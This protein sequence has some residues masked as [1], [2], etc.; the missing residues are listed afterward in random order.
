MSGCGTTRKIP[1][2]Q[3]LL[4]QY[5]ITGLKGKLL[6]DSRPYIRQ[7]PNRKFLGIGF[8]KIYLGIYNTF[9]KPARWK[10]NIRNK[11]GERP[12]IYDS[13]L[14]DLSASQVQQYLF[15]K[16]YFHA[17]VKA[18]DTIHHKK[19]YVTYTADKGEPYTIRNI[20]YS[21]RD[22]MIRTLYFAG[23]NRSK[24][25]LGAIYDQ[26][27]MQQERERITSNL[28]NQGYY[29]FNREYIHFDIDSALGTNQ[30]DIYLVIENR[31]GNIAHQFYRVQ[32][33]MVNVKPTIYPPPIRQRGGSEAHINGVQISDS[34]NK[35]SPKVLRR[36]VYIDSNNLYRQ[37][38]VELTYNRFGD[39]GVFK[40]T[41]IEFRPNPLD[42]T[43]LDCL[44]ELT[45]AERQGTQT[46]L[47]GYAASANVGASVNFIYQNRNIFKGAEILEFRVRGGLE[48][49]AFIDRQKQ[50]GIPVFNSREATTSA[51][52][53]FPKFLFL[54]ENT[55]KG[56]FASPRTRLGFT[57]SFE[58][59]P[60]YLRRTLNSAFT[61]EW[62]QNQFVTHAVSPLDVSFVRSELSDEATKAFE[63]LNNQYLKASF[64]PHIA[65]ASKYSLIINKQIINLVRN[66]YYLRLNL[67]V[68]GTSVYAFSKLIDNPKDANGQYR[69]FDLPYYNYTRPELDF[70]YFDYISSRSQ[71]AYRISSGVGI[72]YWNSPV[73][74]FEKQF[75]IGGS[76]SI[77]AFKAR[78]VGP[79]SFNPQ[80]N[81]STQTNLNIDRTG[82]FKLEGSAEFRFDIFD[83]FFGSKLKG[84]TFFDFGNVWVLAN[85]TDVSQSKFKFDSFY[86]ELALGTGVG[87]RMDYSFLLLR[88][89]LGL[90][91]RDP[92][93]SQNERWVITH[94]SD[95]SWK[96]NNDYSFLNFNFGIGYPF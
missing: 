16:G 92:Q 62:K 33:I 12:V 32:D 27:I 1:D 15:S 35:F 3:A 42:S 25:S 87:L 13:T 45:P 21:I 85:Q 86:K 20:H 93:F 11:L 44:I 68:T 7:K 65:V 61:Y 56:R 70:R 24:I 2:D 37:R 88:F 5:K 96:S 6:E 23:L 69:L 76:N 80:L 52:I 34:E 64:D 9:D 40:F 59:R 67:E 95:R 29:Y 81:D 17:I 94:F 91:L 77:R 53:T 49:Q 26:E 22:S 73:L 63:N 57:Y 79:G 47:E 78:T 90:K 84:A 71:M 89:D 39:L 46:D 43:K 60:E 55:S 36:M 72:T 58:R 83:R 28:K 4:H 31:P 18:S 14:T 48:T 66:Y 75:F 51:T 8:L 10:Q 50:Q 38:D 74:P 41:N 54:S 30:V 82:D 19:A